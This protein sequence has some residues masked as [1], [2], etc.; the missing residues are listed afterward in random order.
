MASILNYLCRYSLVFPHRVLLYTWLFWPGTMFIVA[1][2]CE[3]RQVHIGKGQS[4]TFFPGDLTLG[5][6]FVVLLT[7]SA[8]LQIEYTNDYLT[9][10]AIIA[11]IFAV[12][13][14]A[15]DIQQYQDRRSIASPT[16]I[17]HDICGFF[18]CAWA[19]GSLAFRVIVKS[20]E[21]QSFNQ[22]PGCEKEG[23]WFIYFLEIDFKEG[24]K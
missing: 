13:A 1:I 21:E 18:V 8:L 19:I 23:L 6:D 2:K 16:K 3:H 22:Y 7:L 5:F 11:A 24:A 4:R 20:I 14:W 17:A 9:I 10:T 12:L 15:I